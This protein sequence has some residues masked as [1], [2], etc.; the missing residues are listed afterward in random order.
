MWVGV[1]VRVWVRRVEEGPAGDAVAARRRE[2]AYGGVVRSGL[3]L[4]LGSGS[5]LE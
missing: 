1:G 5:G 3:G 2:G 4:G